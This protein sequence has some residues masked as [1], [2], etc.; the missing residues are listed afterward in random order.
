[1]EYI[2]EA[3]VLA[4]GG[5]HSA[6]LALDTNGKLKVVETAGSLTRPLGILNTPLSFG[7]HG[8]F[9][10]RIYLGLRRSYIIE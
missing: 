10:G 4:L 6:S 1:M 3:E 5:A 9:S 2:I 8:P 7:V